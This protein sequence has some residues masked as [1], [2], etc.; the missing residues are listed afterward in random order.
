MGDVIIVGWA[1]GYESGLPSPLTDIFARTAPLT[2]TAAGLAGG[3]TRA[4]MHGRTQVSV[5]NF[6]VLLLLVVAFAILGL[7]TLLQKRLHK[8]FSV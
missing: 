7:S 2:S 4:G 1:I 3:F 8:R 5:A 6:I